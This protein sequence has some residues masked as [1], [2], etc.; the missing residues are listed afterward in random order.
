MIDFKCLY[1]CMYNTSSGRAW[2]LA[3]LSPS[4]FA[5]SRGFFSFFL[6]V[7]NIVWKWKMN[8]K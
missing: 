2:L 4:V 3:L 6:F 8:G 1:V 5:F 7:A